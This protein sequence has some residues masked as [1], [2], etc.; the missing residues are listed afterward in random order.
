MNVFHMKPE[1]LAELDIEVV[2]SGG[3]QSLIK[4]LQ[5][6]VDRTTNTISISDA[7]LEKIRNYTEGYGEGG[8]QG[9]MKRAFGRF[10]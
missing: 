3:F 4:R 8:F 10:V 7:D 5:D 6:S 9:R 1:E 2:G